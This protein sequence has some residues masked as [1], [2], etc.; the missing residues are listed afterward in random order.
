MKNTRKYGVL[1][2]WSLTPT[3]AVCQGLADLHARVMNDS[4]V[5][6]A[7]LDGCVRLHHVWKRQIIAAHEASALPL[8]QRQERVLSTAY[9][10]FANFWQGYVGNEAAYLR[11]TLR[12]N[13]AE[14]P[15]AALPLQA[16]IGELVIESTRREMEASGRR[17]CAVWYLAFGSGVTNLGG[18]RDGSMVV[19]FF[20][21]PRTD[22]LENIRLILPHELNHISFGAGHRDDPDSGTLLSSIIAEGFGSWYADFYWGDQVTPGKAVGYTEEEWQW[23]LAHEAELW[24]AAQPLLSS[25]E[26]AVH[27]RFRSASTRILPEGPGKVGYFLG[28]R[29]VDAYVKRHGAS[30][31]RALFELPLAR[32]LQESGY[33]PKQ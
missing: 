13:L 4:A 22:A 32:I 21:L 19:D 18:F 2:L 9:R 10:P 12:N 17:A 11:M 23:A 16:N 31:W 6:E 3:A 25:R 20:G 7:G 14:D 33:A 27:D 28:Y 29:I 1:A 15:R 8:E 26:R 30:S 5:V 24:A